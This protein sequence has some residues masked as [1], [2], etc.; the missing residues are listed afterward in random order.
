MPLEITFQSLRLQLSKL[1][2]AACV[3][4]GQSC[5][6]IYS[7]CNEC[8]YALP[9]TKTSC[10]QCGLEKD[11]N[12]M[13]NMSCGHCLINP[14][15]FNYC[16][17]VFRYVSPVNKLVAN[18][19]FNAHFD[20]GHCLSSLMAK[21]MQN[22]YANEEKPQLIIPVPLHRNRIRKRGFNQALEIGK[23]VSRR[24]QIA[25][26]HSVVC[27]SRDTSP[28]TELRSAQARKLN[29]SNAFVVSDK[30][31]L[32]NSSFVVLLD[33]VVTTMATANAISKVLRHQGIRR[34]DVWCLARASR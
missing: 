4:C 24:C 12:T 23:V 1:L 6:N 22:A 17:A 31:A 29:L 30:A 16:N 26:A 8:E 3:V 7:L 21:K 34:I 19:K 32:R 14:P 13:V 28:Q 15:V 18:F 10:K 11:I 27:R 33:D 9:W 5:F 2:P 20:A 25:L